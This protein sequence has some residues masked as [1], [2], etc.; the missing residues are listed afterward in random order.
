MNPETS[1]ELPID[2]ARRRRNR[3]MLIML[4]LI[5]LLPVGGASLLHMAGWKPDQTRNHGELLAAPVALSDISLLRADGSAYAY[6][7]QDRRWQVAVV[8]TSDCG[9]RCVE[10]IAG[11]DKV[12]RLQGRRADRLQVLW[13]GPVP[14]DAA[15]FRTFVPMQPDAALAAR[16]PDLATSGAPTVYLIDPSGF[17]VMRYAPDFDLADLRADVTHLLK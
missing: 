15:L 8:P 9:V 17:L 11:L 2:P 1:G 12:W 6:S 4:A 5:F 13:F 16:M 10:L 14:A 3:I 7:P